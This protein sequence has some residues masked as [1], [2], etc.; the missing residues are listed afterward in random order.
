MQKV[1][2]VKGPGKG[3]E[4]GKKKVWK[5]LNRKSKSKFWLMRMHQIEIWQIFV[6][7]LQESIGLVQ[8]RPFQ[9]SLSS[10]S[11][12]AAKQLV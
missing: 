2:R 6:S 12:M 3:N 5:I 4:R 9:Q 11:V 1:P 10:F 7:N 8:K